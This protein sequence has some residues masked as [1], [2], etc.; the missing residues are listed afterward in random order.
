MQVS[1]APAAGRLLSLDAYRGFIMLAMVTGGLG[2]A[3]FKSDPDWAPVA[4]QLTHLKWEGVTFWDLIQPSF[5]FMVGVSMPFAFAK[6]DERGESWS[7]QFRHV[8]KRCLLLCCIGIVMDSYGHNRPVIQFIRVLQQIAIGYFI[9]F[10][11]L[12]LGWKGELA[13]VVLLLA[14]HSLAYFFD[15]G[16]QAWDWDNRDTSFGRRLDFKIH[17][18]FAS[19]GCSDIWPPAKG[20]PYAI[21]NA[22]SSAATILIGVL[23]GELLKSNSSSGAKALSLLFAGGICW[24]LGLL[25]VHPDLS[26]TVWMLPVKHIWTASFALQAAGWTCW[27][28]L[29]FYLVIDIAGARM[30]AWPF[31]VVGMNSIFIYFCSGVLK[32][33]VNKLTQPFTHHLYQEIGRWE[34]VANAALFTLVLWL[35]CLVLY[36]HR[37][38]FKV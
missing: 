20:G 11:F 27:M 23:I 14:I 4:E 12:K 24:G 13:G 29:L 6:R 33:T 2:M 7:R 35:L 22:V 8:V 10:F 36:R 5:M 30:L 25:L 1:A 3:K 26:E 37:V 9:A 19:F 32:E 34:P 21:F 17:D 31:V 28:M 15:G 18:F 16:S 38:F